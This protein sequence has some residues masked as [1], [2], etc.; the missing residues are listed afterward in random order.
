L[1]CF[2]S[3]ILVWFS[4]VWLLREVPLC[5]PC[6]SWTFDLPAFW[7][8]KLQVCITTPSSLSKHQ[9]SEFQTFYISVFGPLWSSILL[10]TYTQMCILV[11]ILP[12]LYGIHWYFLFHVFK[13]SVMMLWVMTC[14]LENTK[15]HHFFN[16]LFIY[17]RMYI[18]VSGMAPDITIN[19]FNYLWSNFG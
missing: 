13:M 2:G 1:F 11:N 18:S 5:S 8:L 3:F 6:W 10:H 15:S 17:S 12:L 16:L 9:V 14:N 4:L 19:V 7:M